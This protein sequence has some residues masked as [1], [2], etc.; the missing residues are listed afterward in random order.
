MMNSADRAGFQF[1]QAL[2]AKK[3]QDWELTEL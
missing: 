1:Y 2:G 3:V